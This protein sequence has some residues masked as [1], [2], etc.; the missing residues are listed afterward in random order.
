MVIYFETPK[1]ADGT[2]EIDIAVT[3]ANETNQ[4]IID[5]FLV[6]PIAGGPISGVETSRSIPTST[7]T[8]SSLP[9]VVT[10]ATPVGAIVGGVIGGIAGIIILAIALWCFLRRRTGG[11]Q[12][13]HTDGPGPVDILASEGLCTSHRLCRREIRQF[14]QTLL[15]RDEKYYATATTPAQ[16]TGGGRVDYIDRPDPAGIPASEGLYTFHRLCRREI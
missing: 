1:L 8:S 11:G 10:S 6:S 2:H 14:T 15:D 9:V 4:F 13:D 7:S 5:Y 3:T 16:M 12:T